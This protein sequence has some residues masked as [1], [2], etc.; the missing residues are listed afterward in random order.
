MATV[1]LFRRPRKYGGKKEPPPVFSL[2]LG[3]MPIRGSAYHDNCPV[4]HMYVG[5]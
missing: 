1:G 4:L 5:Q 2:F 3:L